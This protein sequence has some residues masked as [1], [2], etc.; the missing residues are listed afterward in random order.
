M[1][2]KKRYLEDRIDQ[3]IT[4]KTKRGKL[5]VENGKRF[6]K[7]LLRFSYLLADAGLECTPKQMGEEEI[8]YL[9]EEWR[10]ERIDART[11]RKRKGLDTD[12]QRWY[13]SILNGYLG[14]YGN[15]VID[16]MEIGWPSETRTNVG[17]INNDEDA[18]RM[19]QVAV[20]VER[21]IIH[22]E[23]RL[24]M[25]RVEVQRLTVQDIKQ[26]VIDVHGKGRYGG[27]WRTLAWAPDTFDVIW[28]YE[29]EREAMIERARRID[30]NVKVPDDWIIYEKGG[31]LSGY[32]NSGIDAIVQRVA[33]RAGIDRKIGNHTLRRTGA[34]M[35]WKAGLD[36]NLIREALGH[37]DLKTTYR[38]IGITVDEL[39]RGQ[40][41]VFNYIRAVEEKMEEKAKSTIGD[42]VNIS[43]TAGIRISS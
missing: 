7:H 35:A 15:H 17:W 31:K 3:Y 11:H 28:E 26:N 8:D 18:V 4:K 12:T 9:L 43:R 40:E 10:K 41:K 6:R 27:K 38:Y 30:P 33:T 32:G 1:P 23:L 5:S 19:T 22:L 21:I 37:K 36:I 13:I 2:S 39:A 24:W 25:R 14:H 20:G 29:Q 42:P 34:R 16:D